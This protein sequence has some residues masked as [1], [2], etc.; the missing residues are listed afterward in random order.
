[1][2]V[3]TVVANGFDVLTREQRD[4]V[5]LETLDMFSTY[6]CVIGQLFPS[7]F[8]HS[9]IRQISGLAWEGAD[10][11]AYEHGF[12]I[13]TDEF[14][15]DWNELQAEWVRRLSIERGLISA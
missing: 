2:N 5:D 12:D 13:N 6:A 15:F 4:R 14:E 8:F 10:E 1:M 3:K 9:G 11:W 7:E